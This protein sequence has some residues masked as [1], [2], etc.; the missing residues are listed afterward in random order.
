VRQAN[1]FPPSF[2]YLKQE[3]EVIQQVSNK[4]YIYLYKITNANTLQIYVRRYFGRLKRDAEPFRLHDYSNVNY[5]VGTSD[6][7]TAISGRVFLV[8]F[9]I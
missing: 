1:S 7:G 6:F 2:L 5:G 3:F 8:H 9:I 4:K